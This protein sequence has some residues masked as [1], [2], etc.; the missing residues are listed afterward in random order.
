MVPLKDF[1]GIN[2]EQKLMVVVNKGV[3]KVGKTNICVIEAL[4]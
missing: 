2:R 3:R 1:R 4:A